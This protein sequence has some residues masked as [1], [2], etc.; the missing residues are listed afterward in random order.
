MASAAI[1]SF[2]TLLQ[3]GDGGSPENFTTIAEVRDI[4][5]PQ[6]TRNTIDVTNHSSPN[7]YEEFVMAIKRSGQ[8]TFEVNFLGTTNA[9]Q[10][11]STGLWAD[12]ENG[13]KSNWKMV[14]PSS[15]GTI[16]FAA[17]VMGIENKAPVDGA[18]TANITLKITGVV[19][20][21]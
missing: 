18:L 7:G 13:T 2:G 11:A 21:A 14:L 16:S 19:T 12:Y 4:T 5:G 15:Y 17:Y 20:L 10:D 6:R 1:S 3:I 9:T 8:M